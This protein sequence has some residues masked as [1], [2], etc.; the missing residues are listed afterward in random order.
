MSA[1]PGPF[2]KIFRVLK[3]FF[4][5]ERASKREDLREES[6]FEKRYHALSSLT[7]LSHPRRWGSE[8]VITQEQ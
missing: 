1:G 7:V 4:P 6:P 2:K 5:G 3:E 8:R